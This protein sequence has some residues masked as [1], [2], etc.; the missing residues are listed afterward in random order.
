MG[1]RVELLIVYF[2]IT[3]YVLSN[4]PPSVKPKSPDNP[5]QHLIHLG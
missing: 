5:N 2:V 4:L 1:G 3:G